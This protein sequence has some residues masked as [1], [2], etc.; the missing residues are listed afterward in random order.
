LEFISLVCY[1]SRRTNIPDPTLFEAVRQ[2][3]IK[4]CSSKFVRPTLFTA[5]RGVAVYIFQFTA[6]SLSCL[7]FTTISKIQT[8]R[9]LTKK[10]SK[11][12]KAV[13]LFHN[14]SIPFQ[15]KR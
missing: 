8:Q 15:N 3:E 11:K 1:Q 7:P 12:R 6:A 9:Q 10:N 14:I 4:Y 5:G 2:Q 13:R